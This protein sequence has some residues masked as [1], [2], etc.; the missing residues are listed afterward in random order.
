MACA[1][2]VTVRYSLEQRVLIYNTY[3]RKKSI[4]KCHAKFRRQFPGISVPYKST[5][6]KL[7]KKLQT[8]GSLL[9]KKYVVLRRGGRECLTMMISLLFE[10]SAHLLSVLGPTHRILKL[11]QNCPL[12]RLSTLPRG[13]TGSMMVITDYTFK[14]QYILI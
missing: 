5:I 7:V 6:Q 11:D 13:K 4:K 9:D 2:L 14:Q 1:Y 10:Q 3:I 12:D 8:T